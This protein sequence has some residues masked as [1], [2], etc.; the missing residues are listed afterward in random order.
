LQDESSIFQDPAFWI[1]LAA[2]FISG[3]Q[4]WASNQA[5]RISDRRTK[6]IESIAVEFAVIENSLDRL[7]QEIVRAK[8]NP[9]ITSSDIAGLA[10]QAMRS[11][12]RSINKVSSHSSVDESKIE[13]KKIDTL[14]DVMN[15]ANDGVFEGEG[16]S[17]HLETSHKIVGRLSVYFM[18]L[19]REIQSAHL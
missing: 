11:S 19:H 1:S 3:Y 18:E 2:L 16:R 7:E 17:L 13:I 12:A 15:F 14:D 8:R 6:F 10:I 9:A 4:A 5:N